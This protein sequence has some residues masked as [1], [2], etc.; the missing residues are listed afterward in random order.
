MAR[1]CLMRT[2]IITCFFVI[3]LFVIFAVKHG[4]ERT[5]QMQTQGQLYQLACA[6]ELY[7]EY[8]Q[9]FPPEVTKDDFGDDLHSWR[10]LLLPFIENIELYESI[11]LNEAWDS[12]HNKR[13]HASNISYYNPVYLR[14][15][16]KQDGLTFYQYIHVAGV[17]GMNGSLDEEESFI[18]FESSVPT[19]WMQPTSY[20]THY[21]LALSK[22]EYLESVM[23]NRRVVLKSA[24]KAALVQKVSDAI[25]EENPSSEQVD[26]L[27]EK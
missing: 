21:E 24:R 16:N 2:I 14:R 8:Y 25:S 17:I 4:Q 23:S 22:S 5:F 15:D 13:F 26:D 6:L 9:C 7:H 3:L 18:L 10:V 1:I 27:D 20:S 19:C 12:G 11:K